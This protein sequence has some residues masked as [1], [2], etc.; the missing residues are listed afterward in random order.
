MELKRRGILPETN[1]SEP[2]KGIFESDTGELLMNT[3]EKLF[4][5]VTPRSETVS[6]PANRKVQLNHLAVSGSSIP[7]TV[8]LHALDS[9]VLN[10]SRHMLLI[11][12]TATANSGMILSEDGATM[13]TPGVQ[14]TLLRTGRL[15]FALDNVHA[16]E[17]ALYALAMD[18]SRIQEL[19]FN[20]RNGKCEVV[21]NT[22]ELRAG[23]VFFEFARK[24]K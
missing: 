22:A 3:R 20:I 11:Y 12:A 5:A 2:S 8:S 16:A 7:A 9:Q 4:R 14:P 1:R 24:Q 18:G 23:T 19:P 15:S 10:R 6:L 21:I 17:F 13:T